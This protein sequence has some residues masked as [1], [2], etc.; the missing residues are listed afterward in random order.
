[1]CGS[2]FGCGFLFILT[3]F[4][5]F[6]VF[7]GPKDVYHRYIFLPLFDTKLNKSGGFWG[8]GRGGRGRF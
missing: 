2:L 8:G 7:Y 6:T 1:M 5:F 3:F 4:P